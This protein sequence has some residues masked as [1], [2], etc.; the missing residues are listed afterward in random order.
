VTY[1]EWSP[2]GQ[3][4]VLVV[5]TGLP[6]STSEDPKVPNAPR[7]VRGV[8]NR[9]D[10]RGWID[11]RTHLFIHELAS[12]SSRQI[13]SG[14]YDH[15]QPSWSPD[16]KHL[17]FITD[18]SRRRNDLLFRGEV[19]TVPSKGGR[20][21]RVSGQLGAPS[22]PSFSPDGRRIAVVAVPQGSQVAGR[23]SQLLVFDPERGGEPVQ[24]A[25][26]LDR[27]I[28]DGSPSAWI[29]PAELLFGVIDQGTLFIARARIGRRDATTVLDGDTQ[30]YGFSA[31]QDRR[32]RRIAFAAG[33]VD[34]PG[35][36]FTRSLDGT[37]EAPV[38]ISRASDELLAAVELVPA[39]RRRTRAKDGLEIEYFEMTPKRSSTGRSSAKRPLYLEIHGGPHGWNPLFVLFPYYQTLVAAGYTVIMPNPRGSVGYGEAFALAVNG[40]WGGDDYGDLMAC[41]DDAV[42][43][44][45]AD[46]RRLFVGGYSYGGYM[47]SFIVGQTD[48][49]K[50]AIIGAPVTNL[51]SEYGSSDVG[52]WLAETVGGDPW[53]AEAAWRERS[54]I[55]HAPNVTTPV[56]LHVNDGDLRTPPSQADEFYAALKLRGK[57]VEYVRYPG[58]SHQAAVPIAAPPSQNVD[59]LWRILDFLGRHGGN[60]VRTA[61]PS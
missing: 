32:D 3:S 18:R 33:W 16:S 30:V 22:W 61:K 13:T 49:F 29:S 59:R 47:S 60:R 55:T 26:N 5:T 27:P 8:F 46:E 25:P 7:V 24:V 17:V 11:G 42:R 43:R 23:N 57:D 1:I 58:G 51:S 53:S 21:E 20:P 14:D 15:A 44:G 45:R 35:D 36:V 4:I 50:A 31:F 37:S 48:R 34:Q 38:R 54:P 56:F 40:D 28:W 41:V 52:P 6:D 10:T 39:R 19:W 12:G 9:L 2:D